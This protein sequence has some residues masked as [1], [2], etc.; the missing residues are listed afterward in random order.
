MNLR[1]IISISIT[2]QTRPRKVVT[3]YGFTHFIGERKERLLK[4]Q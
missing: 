1:A 4:I 3:Q 2:I